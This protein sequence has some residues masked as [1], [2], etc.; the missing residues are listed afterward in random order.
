MI[1]DLRPCNQVSGRVLVSHGLEGHVI[2]D[3]HIKI[4]G[5]PLTVDELVALLQETKYSVF[6]HVVYGSSDRKNFRC[7]R[8]GSLF[9]QSMLLKRYLC[10]WWLLL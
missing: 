4:S 3:V 8:K 2:G 5:R 7:K 10:L 1:V 9:L 6:F